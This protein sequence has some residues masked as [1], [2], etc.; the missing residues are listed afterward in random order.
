MLFHTWTFAAF[1]LIFYSV[2]L[3]LRKTRAR[4]PWLL[5]ASYVFYGWWNP[6]YLSLILWSTSVDYVAVVAMARTGR[7]K[8]WLCLSLAN[9]LGLLGFFKYGKF[10][11]ENLN[12]LLSSMGVPYEIPPPDVLL[13][14]GI[15]FYVF[16]SMSY[17]IDFFRGK[18]ER[19]ASFLRYATFVS[20][21]PQLV[22]GPIERA[23]NLLPQLR[24]TPEISRNDVAEGLSLFV[25]GLFKKVALADYLALYA[26]PIYAT[27]GRYEAPALMLATFA[28]AWQIYFDFSGYTD[29]A[30]GIG[31]MMGIRLMLNFNNPYLAT[32]L[33]DF[34]R[35]WHIS[36][37]SWFRDYVYIPLGG[38]RRGEIRTYV[39]I[40]LTM[41]VSGLWHG[42][43]WTFVIWGALHAIGYSVTRSLERLPQ[44]QDRVPTLAKQVFTFGFVTFAWIF[45]RAASVSDAW[46]IITRI[47]T[48]ALTDA[49][50]PWLLLTLVF[51]V[52]LYQF[53]YESSVRKVLEPRPVRVGL[54]VL[55]VLYVAVAGGSGDNAF[56]YFQF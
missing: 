42:A 35:R 17:T 14:V 47:F 6:L 7:K 51:S 32:G 5:L 3:L 52:W 13:P 29:M 22:A 12:D 11:A 53:M 21:F 34:W 45:F 39:N 30:R 43:M 46:L 31:R 36:L 9:N 56:I 50:C 8:L 28:F 41:V 1:F 19:E 44:Y 2:Y 54:V 20:L 26:D 4:T 55:M 40:G 38:N 33:G 16:Q 49:L 24:R 48:T 15:S 25:V 27:P 37:S 10:V 23:T 18:I